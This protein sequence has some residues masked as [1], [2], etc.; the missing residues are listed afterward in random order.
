MLARALIQL[1]P[2]GG[3][4]V[5]KKNFLNTINWWFIIERQTLRAWLEQLH[6]MDGD[7]EEMTLRN[8]YMWFLLLMLQNVKVCTP[9]DKMPPRELKPIKDIVVSSCY[10]SSSP[11]NTHTHNICS[12]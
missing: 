5:Y 11:S 6:R 1:M 3:I 10:Y 9:F 2:V 8:D 4:I 7:S 12:D